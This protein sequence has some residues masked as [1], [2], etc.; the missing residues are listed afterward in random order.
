MGLL[1]HPEWALTAYGLESL[2]GAHAFEGS[3]VGLDLYGMVQ[4]RYIQVNAPPSAD[5][6]EGWDEALTWMMD[7]EGCEVLHEG[8]QPKQP[9][10]RPIRRRDQT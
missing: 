1:I 5:S 6:A 8:E 4:R 3:S 7:R 10:V 9:V 2:H